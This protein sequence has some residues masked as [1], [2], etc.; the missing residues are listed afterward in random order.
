MRCEARTLDD[1]RALGGNDAADERRF[2]TAA[3]RLGDQSRALPHLRAADRSRAGQRPRWRSGCSSCTRCGCSTKL[4]SDA[5]PLMAPIATHGRTGSREPQARAADNPI[6]RHAG[7][8]VPP[9]RRRARRAGAMRARQSRR[10]DVPLGLRLADAAGRR[11]HRSCRDPSACGRRPRIRCIANCCRS[12]SPSSN[13]A[14]RPAA[15][16]KRI[17]RGLLYVGMARGGGR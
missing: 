2:A 4:F 13:R 1:I 14:S 6:R 7:E 11:R 16:A 15:C 9:D 10:A 3:T 8:R 12:G 17:I 5:N